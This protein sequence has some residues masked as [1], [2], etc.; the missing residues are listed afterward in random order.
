MQSERTQKAI[1]E[2]TKATLGTK[3]IKCP[4]CEKPLSFRNEI[5]F[6]RTAGCSFEK[7]FDRNLCWLLQDTFGPGQL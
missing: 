1:F 3:T 5:P 6:C 2:R 4:V 7:W